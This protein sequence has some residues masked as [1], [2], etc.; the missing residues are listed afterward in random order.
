M[1][2]ALP[3][4]CSWGCGS[5]RGRG[6][7]GGWRGEIGQGPRA[8]AGRGRACLHQAP[9]PCL[10]PSTDAG[11]EARGGVQVGPGGRGAAR[12]LCH[13][14]GAQVRPCATAP[15]AACR[16]TAPYTAPPRHRT[17]TTHPGPSTR[18]APGRIRYAHHPSRH[19]PER[20]PGPPSIPAHHPSRPSA[21]AHLCVRHA[22][23]AQRA[24]RRAPCRAEPFPS[25]HAAA[26]RG[27]ARARGEPAL[28]RVEARAQRGAWRGGHGAA[29]TRCAPGGEGR[30]RVA[31]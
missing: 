3:A 12:A 27:A 8:R 24:G 21:C 20:S 6:E 22:R 10:G 9:P 29:H 18:S 14:H 2:P 1:G 19:H 17:P 11:G 7:V 5:G 16:A 30:V 25:R 26:R 31:G 15:H 23:H 13:P 4:G 28:R